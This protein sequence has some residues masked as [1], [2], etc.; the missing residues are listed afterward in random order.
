MFLIIKVI[1]GYAK[2]GR[3]FLK[4]TFIKSFSMP[5]AYQKSGHAQGSSSQYGA[6]DMRY[7]R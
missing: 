1:N 6:N 2:P 4:C 7:C 5:H 3:D